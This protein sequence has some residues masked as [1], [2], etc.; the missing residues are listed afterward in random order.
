[1]NLNLILSELLMKLNFQPLCSFHCLPLQEL[2]FQLIYQ[3]N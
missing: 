3:R 2:I 1:M